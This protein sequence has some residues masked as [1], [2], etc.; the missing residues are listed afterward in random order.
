MLKGIER[1]KDPLRDLYMVAATKDPGKR[2][3]RWVRDEL[4]ELV[5]RSIVVLD[6]G[7]LGSVATGGEART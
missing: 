5:G 2:V 4:I 3:Q 7:G 6:E 1:T